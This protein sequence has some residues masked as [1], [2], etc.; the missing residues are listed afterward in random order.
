MSFA[1]GKMNGYA[2]PPEAMDAFSPELAQHWLATHS[3]KDDD[4]VV[5]RRPEEPVTQS[6]QAALEALADRISAARSVY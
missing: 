3:S 1:S 6:Q 4:V 5:A 2:N